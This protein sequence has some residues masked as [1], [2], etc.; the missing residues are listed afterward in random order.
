MAKKELSRRSFLKGAAAMA[1]MGLLAGCTAPGAE[2]SGTVNTT[3]APVGTTAANDEK[4]QV[5]LP[6]WAPAK[7]D[8]EADVVICGCG[9]AGAMAAREAIAQGRSCVILE[10]A[11]PEIAGG[12]TVCFGGYYVPYPSETL[13]ASSNGAL[14][15]DEAN[16]I[17]EQMVN[18][19]TWMMYNGMTT[20]DFYKVDGEGPGFYG[21]LMTAL[22][23]MGTNIMYETPVKELVMDPYTKEVYGV[24]AE[25][26]NGASIYVKANKGVVLATGSVSGNQ[27]LLN[28]FFV[29][30]GVQLLNVSSPAN[31]GDGL[32]MGLSAG[33]ALH[34]MTQHGLELDHFAMKKASEEVGTGMILGLSGE[35][36]GARIFVNKSGQRFMNEETYVVHYKGL[37]PWLEYPGNA[38]TGYLGW[39]NAPFYM[40]F[41]SKLA[42]SEGIGTFLYPHG[43][44]YSFKSYEWSANNQAEVE[45]GWIAKGDTIEDLV[46]NLAQI[47]GNEAIDAEALKASIAAYNDQCATG[48]DGYGRSLMQPIEQGPFYAVELTAALMYT[49][50]GLVCSPVGETLDW[51]GNAIPGLYSAGDIGQLCETAPQGACGCGA[52]GALAVRSMLAKADR[53][54]PGEVGTVIGTPNEMAMAVAVGGLYALMGGDGAGQGGEGSTEGSG[55]VSDAVY[56]DGTYTGKGSSAIGGKIEVSVTVSGGK[57]ASIQ[58]LSHNESKDIGAKALDSLIGQ[59]VSA[60]GYQIDGIS[61]ATATSNGFAAAVQDAL[62]QA[63]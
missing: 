35:N 11:S 21:V 33:A 8:Y 10:K 5:S 30:K 46:A 43:W 61:G 55:V 23:T 38:E 19:Y 47:S 44:A 45:K 34:N 52:M 51:N 31:T 1:G 40:V 28:R 57:V 9:V 59:A 16:V 4:A 24:R 37:L 32:L 58:V 36:R 22:Q 50:G 29:P 39:I 7:W 13:F 48:V 2:T 49:I 42:D 12:S 56:K 54:I 6:Q 63:Q 20:N 62:A 3:E 14:T 27:D 26:A 15:Q 41:D 60:N 25:D 17:G 53:Q 18:D